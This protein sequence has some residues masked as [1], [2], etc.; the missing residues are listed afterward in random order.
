MRIPAIICDI[1]GTLSHMTHRGPFDWM[2]VGTDS[3]DD[4]VYRILDRFNDKYKI[5]LV[6]GRD[7]ICREITETWLR[8]KNIHYDKLYMRPLGDMRRD[9]EV[10]RE[11][12]DNYIK[13]NYEIFFVL[14]DRNQVVDMWR[15]IGLKC[16]Q[17]APGDF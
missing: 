15:E 2:K 13:D 1:D 3:L 11:I 10:K 17:V 6:S 9:V 8:D 16:L 7:S 5:I 14:D 4:V 12:Y